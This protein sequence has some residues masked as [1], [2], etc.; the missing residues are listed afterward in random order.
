MSNANTSY[1]RKKSSNKNC[2]QGKRVILYQFSF[3]YSYKVISYVNYE[4]HHGSAQ[5]A[6]TGKKRRK[7]SLAHFRIAVK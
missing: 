4:F 6:S 3:T 5:E 7:N 1:T 2:I